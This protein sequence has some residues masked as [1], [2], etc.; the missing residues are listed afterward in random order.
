MTV[1][2]KISFH[3]SP[4]PKIMNNL[5]RINPQFLEENMVFHDLVPLDLNTDLGPSVSHHPA[6]QWPSFS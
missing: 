2:I 4:D 1:V 3:Q 5:G 6:S